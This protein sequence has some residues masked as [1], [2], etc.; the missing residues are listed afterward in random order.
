MSGIVDRLVVGSG[1][2]GS[3]IYSYGWGGW[4]LKTFAR[5]LNRFSAYFQIFGW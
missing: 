3:C 1:L 4:G 2:S 5:N